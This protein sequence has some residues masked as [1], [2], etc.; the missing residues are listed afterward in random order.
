[1][2]TKITFF[3]NHDNNIHREIKQVHREYL[4]SKMAQEVLH[5]ADVFL[6]VKKLSNNVLTLIEHNHEAVLLTIRDNKNIQNELLNE[7][8]FGRLNVDYVDENNVANIAEQ[9]LNAIKQVLTAEKMDLAKIMQIHSVFIYRIYLALPNKKMSDDNTFNKYAEALTLFPKDLFEYSNRGRIMS[10]RE[11][12]LSTKLGI[13]RHS[14][15]Y[16]MLSDSISHI[17]AIDRFLVQPNSLFYLKS[18]QVNMPV[19]SG[20]SS[21]TKSF[22]LGAL[23]YGDF[24]PEE[25]IEYTFVCAAFLIAGGNHSFHE[26][27][28]VAKNAGIPYKK[29][30]YAECLPSSFIDLFQ[31]SEMIYHFPELFERVE[32]SL[33]NYKCASIHA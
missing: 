4:E 15:R 31:R 19:V 3:I 12:V 11:T 6:S 7:I 27:M 24:T 32:L 8:Y 2:K 17:R 16:K 28:S 29:G 20:L 21:H 26:V 22:L 9:L 33:D 10:E 1:M 23:A 30:S 5:N 13:S 14:T 18:M 25:L